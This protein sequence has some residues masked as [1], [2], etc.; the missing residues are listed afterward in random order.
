MKIDLDSKTQVRLL[1]LAIEDEDAAAVQQLLA[2]GC[3]VDHPDVKKHPL[4]LAIDC[5]NQPI[6]EALLDAGAQLPE[7]GEMPEIEAAARMGGLRVIEQALERKLL[8]QPRLDL[9]LFD[10]VTR[11]RKI[12]LRLLEA[13]ANPLVKMMRLGE[14]TTAFELAAKFALPEVVAFTLTRLDQRQKDELLMTMVQKGEAPAVRS[15]IDAGASTSQR[16]DRA[17]TLLQLAKTEEVRRLLRSVDT[18]NHL[19][20]AMRDA[21]DDAAPPAKSSFTL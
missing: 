6:V 19:G 12:A 18:A 13:G 15:L 10:A 2:A 14:Q 21:N 11:D 9:L 20:S 7:R 8:P 17:R 3:P 16:G 5:S 4:S 1:C